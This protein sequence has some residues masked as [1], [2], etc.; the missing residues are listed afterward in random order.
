MDNC[1]RTPKTVNPEQR[2][3]TKVNFSSLSSTPEGQDSFH[4]P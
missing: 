3:Y 4:N 2:I 1:Y